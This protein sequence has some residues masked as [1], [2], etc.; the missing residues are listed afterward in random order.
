MK[1]LDLNVYDVQGMSKEEMQKTDGGILGALAVG[2][3]GA[4]IYD[5]CKDPSDSWSSFSAGM[6]DGLR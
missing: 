3:L 5:I 6:S 4:L 1:E 2:F